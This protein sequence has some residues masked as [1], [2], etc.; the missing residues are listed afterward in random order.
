MGGGGEGASLHSV[1]M[2]ILAKLILHVLVTN[3]SL[4]SYQGTQSLEQAI[5]T[6]STGE[7][8]M[9]TPQVQGQNDN[10]VPICQ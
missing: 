10:S 4:G 6:G 2:M 7:S 1:L 8:Y 3:A 9:S 5:Q